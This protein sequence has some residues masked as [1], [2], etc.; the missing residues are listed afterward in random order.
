MNGYYTLMG[1]V[2]I[3]A[4]WKASNLERQQDPALAA[5]TSP[6]RVLASRLAFVGHEIVRPNGVLNTEWF[7][8]LNKLYN[9]KYAVTLTHSPNVESQPLRCPKSLCLDGEPIVAFN[10]RKVTDA[11]VSVNADREVACAATWKQLLNHGTPQLK[12]A[13]DAVI[14]VNHYLTLICCLLD[15]CSEGLEDATPPEKHYDVD[16]NLL[17]WHDQPFLIAHEGTGMDPV[18]NYQEKRILESLSH[19]DGIVECS[20]TAITYLPDNVVFMLDG[21]ELKDI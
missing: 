3:D 8:Q 7:A 15:K 19:Y 2:K 20:R 13:V 16:G 12:T 17:P 9:S 5:D 11:L 1:G 21:D 4:C 10:K 6:H 18:D 14:V